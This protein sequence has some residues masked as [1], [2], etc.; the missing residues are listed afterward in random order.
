MMHILID[1]ETLST[2]INCV[3][4]QIG[5]CAFDPASEG[6]MWHES[7]CPDVPNQIHVLGRA[8]DW[9]TL[10]WWL[11]QEEDARKAM[12]QARPDC[13]LNEFL[14][15]FAHQYNWKDVEGVWSHGLGFDV[16]ILEYAYIKAGMSIPWGY[17]TPRDT[18]TLFALAGMKSEDLIAPSI[19]HVAEADAIAM[20]LSVQKA[21]RWIKGGERI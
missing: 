20:A 19:K 1:T 2:R 7:K 17:K 21:F 9:E 16:S 18:R 8:I 3:I 12:W 5:W 11:Q 6:V 4:T 13:M 10:Q 14:S 15:S